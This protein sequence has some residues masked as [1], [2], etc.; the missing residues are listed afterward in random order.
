M[1]STEN[2]I[3]HVTFIQRYKIV[4]SG[5]KWLNIEILYRLITKDLFFFWK[6]PKAI[7]YVRIILIIHHC[8]RMVY[9]WIICISLK[10][11]RKWLCHQN[12]YVHSKSSCNT[13]LHILLDFSIFHLMT[14]TMRNVIFFTVLIIPLCLCFYF[15]CASSKT[16]NE[17]QMVKKKFIDLDLFFFRFYVNK[18]ISNKFQRCSKPHFKRPVSFIIFGHFLCFSKII[19]HI[20]M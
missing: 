14:V 20:T 12:M 17:R 3:G 9:N 7:L 6:V 5:N 10:L 2:D 15:L 13:Y 18:L 1:H 11:N 19:T 8:I 4:Y 16:T